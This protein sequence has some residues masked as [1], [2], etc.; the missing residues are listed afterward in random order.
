MENYEY[1]EVNRLDNPHNYMYTPYQGANFVNAYFKNR[2]ENIKRFQSQGNQ[3]YIDIDLHFCFKSISQLKEL[4]EKA[5]NYQ[6]L[7]REFDDLPKLKEM[8]SLLEQDEMDQLKF[9][10]LENEIDTERLLTS[11]LFNQLNN[12]NNR[13]IKEWLDLLIQRFEVTKKLYTT[14]PK[15]FR[16]GK[17]KTNVV[18]LYWM[19]ALLLNLC[20]VETQNIKYLSTLLKVSDLL[21][22]LG[23]NNRLIHK[24]P[25]Q[26]LVLILLVEII[27]IRSLSNNIKGINFVFK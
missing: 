14:Y 24:I 18:R 19:F 9:I 3:S 7:T 1:T 26:G 16:S 12:K 27:N 15:G 22:S 2:L 11:I 6:S 25:K 13:L 8:P 10:K 21:C 23:S 17:G 20:Y 4:L 5:G